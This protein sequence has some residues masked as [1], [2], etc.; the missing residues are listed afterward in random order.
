MLRAR[1][2]SRHQGQGRDERET[3]EDR[4]RRPAEEPR[5][6]LLVLFGRVAGE[7]RSIALGLEPLRLGRE[8]EDARHVQ[9]DDPL[10]SRR[11]AELHWSEV[12]GRYWVRDLGSRNGVF[13]NG[14]RIGREILARGDLVR[15]GDTVFQLAVVEP[16]APEPTTEVMIEA[17]IRPPFVG[18]SRSLRRS[19]ELAARVAA[20]DTPVLILGPT[21]TGK[22]LIA[23][24]IHRASHR[25]GPL[26]PVNCAALPGNLV[27]SEL[28]GH[29]RGAFSGADA[30]RAGLFRTAHAGTLFLDEVGELAPEIQAKLL[31][32]L[33]SRSIRPVGAVAEAPINVRVLAAT[34]RD[35]VGEVAHGRFRADLYA[36][37]SES[38]VRLDPLRDRPE[39]LEPLWQHFVAQLGQG[40]S[41]ALGGAVFEAMAL[42]AWPFNVREL[43]QLV[44][45]ALLARPGGGQLAIEDLPA[46]MQP[47]RDRPAPARAAESAS[48]PPLL[49]AGEVPSARQLRQLVE[50]FHGNIKDVAAFLGKD[51]KQIYRWLRR[52]HIDPDAY[53]RGNG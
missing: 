32:V 26:V 9:L 28:F 34:N 15:I 42:H 1:V 41:L 38:V 12:H 8:V 46:A 36:R 45:S 23:A 35:L 18:R 10:V 11:H 16:E 5:H 53:R 29:E 2:S 44:R 20:L 43:R 24:A 33:E 21:G 13:V 14:V 31:R 50:E 30:S 51:R 4:T 48:A 39:D 52:D 17:M 27:E 3:A 22:D 19:L 25:T 49:A 40:A 6:A 47:P 37:L 7:R